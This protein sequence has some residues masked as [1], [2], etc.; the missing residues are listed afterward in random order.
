[1]KAGKGILVMLL[2]CFLVSG[3]WA[4]QGSRQPSGPEVRPDPEASS[5][6]LPA[7]GIN[8]TQGSFAFW[9][10]AALIKEHED[11]MTIYGVNSLHGAVVDS[12]NDHR[13][14]MSLAMASLKCDGEIKILNAGCVSKSYPNFFSVFE[15]LGGNVT[16]ED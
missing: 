13:V 7:A 8:S 2:G 16:Y 15:K 6:A 11:G 4:C 10:G 3:L 14:A 12:H 9:T 5:E 1:M